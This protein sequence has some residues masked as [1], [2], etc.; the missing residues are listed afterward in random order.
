MNR[1]HFLINTAWGG[2]ALT[3]L[4]AFYPFNKDEI[5]AVHAITHG[6]NPHWFGYYDK[7]QIDA[8]G[9]YALG[10]QLTF[11]GRSPS[12]N[13]LLRIGVIDLQANNSWTEIGTSRAW[14]WQQG[15]M[16]QWVPGK[17]GDIIW[18][19]RDGDKFISRVYNFKTKKSRTLP[20]A[21]YALSP[22]GI[23]AI[24]TEFNR[25]QNLRPGYGYA[26]ITD[27]YEKEK[28]PDKIGIYRMNLKTGRHKLLIPLAEMAAIPHQGQPVADNWHWFNHLLVSPDSKR[29]L[30][31]HRWREKITDRQVM[32]SR[33]FITRMITADVNGK[34]R[35]VLDPSGNSSHFV[36]K[37]PNNVFVWTKPIGKPWGFYL[38]EDKT[39][40]QEI[41]G[42][43]TMTQNGH[44]TYVPHTNKE[45][46]LND[47]YPDK[48]RIQTLYLYHIP[49]KRQVILGKF[50]SPPP[51]VG[52][53]RCDL[54]PRCNQQGTQVFFDSTH[55]GKGRQM[56]KIDIA[57]IIS[58]L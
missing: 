55:E 26:G 27:P 15:C 49:T 40:N 54:H 25:I 24:G 9:R 14:G 50:F 57:K 52:E 2:L 56:Y 35:Y 3:A 20:K 51:Y 39:Q 22:D 37:D 19:D 45:W 12:E 53:W 29:F 32:A 4:P 46:V 42:A 38:L 5:P 7:W 58:T 17:S 18:N 1:R 8:T 31:L 33:G 13:D 21:I 48:D 10:C 43:E 47:T 16:L 28:A 36:W 41:V 44:N 23:F 11:E 6:P 34:D 30:F